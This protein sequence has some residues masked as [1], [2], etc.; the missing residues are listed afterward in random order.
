MSLLSKL[1][2]G[3]S[4][5]RAYGRRSYGGFGRG[6]GGHGRGRMRSTPGGFFSSPIGRIAMVG[7]LATYA[8]RRF[9]GRRRMY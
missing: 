7:G 5:G 2:G 8:A 4:R 1:F 3:A 6:R 9:M